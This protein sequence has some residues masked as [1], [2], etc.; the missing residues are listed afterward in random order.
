MATPESFAQQIPQAESWED[1]MWD[2]IQEHAN[3]PASGN[4][5]DGFIAL[6]IAN[7]ATKPLRWALFG[8]RD[9]AIATS[10]SSALL[11]TTLIGGFI[12]EHE[13]H[14]GADL[15]KAKT[16]S[17]SKALVLNKKQ[18]LKIADLYFKEKF[19]ARDIPYTIEW[20]P[21]LFDVIPDYKEN[22]ELNGVGKCAYTLPFSAVTPNYNQA[23]SKTDYTID[24]KQLKIDCSWVE[25]PVIQD[26]VMAGNTRKYSAN[27]FRSNMVKNIS[28]SA[29]HFSIDNFKN[30]VNDIDML[31]ERAM[32]NK[33]LE[34]SGDKCSSELD[35]HLEEAAKESL[36]ANVESLGQKGVNVGETHFT[37]GQWVFTHEQVPAV[38]Q[39]AVNKTY[40]HNRNINVDQNFSVDD[41]KCDP[42]DVKVQ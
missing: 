27:G 10:V 33:A 20:K 26:F 19:T 5:E 7:F 12:V 35:T 32:T 40:K 18:E 41:I 8:S 22:K 25:T 15:D 24:K 16:S 2:K 13:I 17:E 14:G 38:V 31:A 36:V 39:A 37:D 42:K 28:E 11:A 6:D 4:P 9:R 30:A 34:V 29:T 21:V 23:T 3:R 1:H